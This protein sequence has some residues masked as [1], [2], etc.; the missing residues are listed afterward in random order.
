MIRTARLLLRTIRDGAVPAV[1]EFDAERALLDKGLWE[2]RRDVLRGEW[3]S[4]RELIAA[5]GD[6][7]ELRG[8]RILSLG[9][10]AVADGRW[11]D[12]WREAHPDDPAATLM[13]SARIREQARQARGSASAA[14]TTAQ[15]FAD[16]HRLS[17]ET[18]EVVRRAIDLAAPGDPVP[19]VQLLGTLYAGPRGRDGAIDEVFEEGRRRD[20]GNFDLHLHMLSLRC[21]KWYGSHERMFA[22][23]REVA[24]TA[25]DGTN[26]VLLP[27]FAHFEYAMQEYGWDKRSAAVLRD[28]RKYFRRTEVRQEV[29]R[30]IAKWRAGT[31]S[32]GRLGTCRHWVALY[33]TLTGQ[34]KAARAAFAE[35]GKYVDPAHAWAYFHP[36]REYGFFQGWRWANGL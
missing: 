28:C 30:C 19:W 23:G 22:I 35:I 33:Y 7:W 10:L 6:D 25:P 27:L 11:L 26:V 3:E 13:L 1:P 4:A 18:A 2:T 36:N 24:E 15:Q 12:A 17:E 5:A 16:F 21:R 9:E 20:P 29:D 8:T 31:P 32:I 34:R 14:H